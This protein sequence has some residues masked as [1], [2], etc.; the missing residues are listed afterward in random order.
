MCK[1]ILNDISKYS[2]LINKAK[3]AIT[4]LDHFPNDIRYKLREHVIDGTHG[5]FVHS[6]LKNL[7]FENSLLSYSPYRSG[8]Y[9]YDYK[10]INKI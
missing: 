9:E 3:I 2:Y 7:G 10:K 5:D 6:I 1:N 8:I 4:C